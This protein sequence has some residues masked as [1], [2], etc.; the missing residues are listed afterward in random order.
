MCT[1]LRKL[2]PLKRATSS[3]LKKWANHKQMNYIHRYKTENSTPTFVGPI[4]RFHRLILAK[5]C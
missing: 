2:E 4:S 5:P 1:G 3:K